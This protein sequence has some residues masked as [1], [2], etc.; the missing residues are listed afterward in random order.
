VNP[1]DKR[2]VVRPNAAVEQRVDTLVDDPARAKYKTDLGKA[3]AY[4]DN[5]NLT[6]S[7]K[8]MEVKARNVYSQIQ[9][10]L[11]NFNAEIRRHPS[12]IIDK[13]KTPHKFRM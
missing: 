5:L 4:C 7:P 11:R 9:G 8:L 2:V 6:L 1:A 10:Y 12:M 13:A 3:K